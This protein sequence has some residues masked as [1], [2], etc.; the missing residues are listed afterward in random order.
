VKGSN[1]YFGGSGNKDFLYQC[2]KYL[3]AAFFS[4]ALLYTA[5]HYQAFQKESENFPIPVSAKKVMPSTE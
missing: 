4:L 5:M 3:I 1:S 2:T